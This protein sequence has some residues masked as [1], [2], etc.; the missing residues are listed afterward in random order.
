MTTRS[1][2]IQGGHRP[3]RDD[4][5]IAAAIRVALVF[6][7]CLF[8][9]SHLPHA[10]VAVFL[11]SLLL[12]S[13]MI[14]AGLAVFNREYPLV[15]HFTRWD[16]AAALAILGFLTGFFIDPQAVT[17]ALESMPQSAG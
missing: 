12:L 15:D 9:A 3:D 8:L 16:E 14:S 5:N 4:K 17:A 13:A 6:A 10:L 2:E 11:R 7:I 1:T